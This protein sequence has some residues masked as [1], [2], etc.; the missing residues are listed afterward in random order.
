MAEFESYTDDRDGKT[1][2][3]VKIGNLVWMAQNLNFECEDSFCYDDK[4]ENAEKYGRLYQWKSI[5]A[6]CPVG[7]HL[8]SDD[9]WNAMLS[10]VR[11]NNGGEAVGTSLKATED[12]KPCE[13]IA[14]ATDR[15]GFS[16]LP[17]GY[18]D[19]ENTFCYIGAYAFFW[20]ST[21]EKTFTHGKNL[22]SGFAGMYSSH[23]NKEVKKGV[24]NP[25]AFSLRLVRD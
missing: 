10:F 8:P 5:K 21:E 9:E 25:C 13:F 7:L 11:E 23:Q 12:W 24:E 1:Y 14:K 4:P 16:A 17:A 3:M 18:R 19:D 2:R 6:A 15:F 20:T 22:C